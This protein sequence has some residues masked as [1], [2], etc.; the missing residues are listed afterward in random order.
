MKWSLRLT[1]LVGI[2]HRLAR[3]CLI[4]T[5]K[6]VEMLKDCPQADFQIPQTVDVKPHRPP[7]IK[8]VDR[9][10]TG[11]C[12]KSSGCRIEESRPRVLLQPKKTDSLAF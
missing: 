10:E 7:H 8:K 3:S 4:D 11:L 5:L 6:I 1:L 12:P 2:Y 9:E